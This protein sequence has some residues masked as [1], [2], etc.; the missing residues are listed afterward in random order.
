MEEK[1]INETAVTEAAEVK[2][3][4][5]SAKDF[6]K[7]LKQKKS[8]KL[9]NQALFK[10]GGYSLAIT[11]LFLVG[12]ILFN[13]LVSALADRFNL[14]FDMTATKQN[15]ITEENL[16]FIKDVKNPVSIVFCAKEDDYVG[17]MMSSYASYYYTVSDPNEANYYNQ[18]IN[19]VKKYADV[20]KNITL[21]FIDTQSTEFAKIASKY[22]NEN[23]SYGDIIVSGEVKGDDGKNMSRYKIISYQDIYTLTDES[24]MAAYGAGGYTIDGNN[25]ETVVTS[26]ISIVTSAETKKVLLLTGHSDSNYTEIFKKLLEVNGYE[27]TVSDD[28]L[29]TSISKEFDAVAILAPNKDFLGS[30]LDKIE[31]FLD[32]GEALGKGLLYFADATLPVL[33]NFSEFLLDW[34]IEMEDGILFETTANNRLEG[35]PYTMGTFPAEDKITSGMTYCI[36]NYNVPLAA[37]DPADERIGV[38]SLMS[39]S[40]TVVVA[41]KGSGSAWDDYSKSDMG[42]YSSVIQAEKTD[43]D[44]DNMEVS[45]YVIA[46]SSIEF[47][48]SD[49]AEYDA[50]SNKNIALAAADRAT[51]VEN[52]GISFIPKIIVNESFADAVSDASVAV[53][54]MIFMILLPIAIVALGV[55]IFIRRKNA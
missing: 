16:D 20:N 38:T 35:D 24:G 4:K 5:K 45:S 31:E 22:S 1:N 40:P 9:K 23:I 52:T 12:I 15:T 11:A 36:T 37:T 43:I 32:N 3:D 21:E 25:I 42:T 47:I 27:I 26:A 46:F 41:P 2:K 28:A 6:L 49:W 14:E 17:G 7:A 18:T 51:G 33:P 54:R 29:I 10:R 34:G 50:L 48:Y 19:L 13:W 30:E 53:V 55:V 44:D 8:T 39:T